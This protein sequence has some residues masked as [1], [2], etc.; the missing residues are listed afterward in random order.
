MRAI[1]RCFSQPKS[2]ILW[3][4]S[5][6]KYKL[7]NQTFYNSIIPSWL[8]TS[9]LSL[10]VN[11][12]VKKNKSF[13]P[14]YYLSICCSDRSQKQVGKRD[15]ERERKDMTAAA[16][17]KLTE[18]LLVVKPPISATHDISKERVRRVE[19]EI[20]SIDRE[21]GKPI[22]WRTRLL[23]IYLFMREQSGKTIISRRERE[24]KEAAMTTK[25]GKREVR[26]E[27]IWLLDF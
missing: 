9:H 20:R 21:R 18:Q 16:A 6:S 15:K 12:W 10:V 5:R 22:Q 11:G 24:R 27:H 4:S 8:T 25:K 1:K 13:F 17:N 3:K 23:S 26:G 7:K 19:S 2:S 14:S